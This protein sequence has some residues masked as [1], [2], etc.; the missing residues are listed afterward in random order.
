MTKFASIRS[1][2]SALTSALALSACVVGP[3][4]QRPTT[5]ASTPD[6]AAFAEAAKTRAV[7]DAALPANWWRLYDDPTLDRLV[8]DALAHNT[9]IRE[10]AANLAQAR[11]ILSEQSSRRLPTTDLSSQATYSRTAGA[12]SPTGQAFQTDF[13]SVG[14]DAGYEV[15]LFGGIT[16]AIQAA[17]GDVDA[18]AAQLDAARVSIAAET[19]RSYAT[20]CSNAA[21]QAV[22]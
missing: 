3:N 8:T 22:A 20:A 5:P 19:A 2:A 11:A 15:D 12:Q 14:F 18:A 10:A 1:V 6:T 21:Q 4:Y 7:N 13:Y 9:D 17:R 16:R